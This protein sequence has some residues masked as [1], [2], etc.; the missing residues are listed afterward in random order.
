MNDGVR[1][2]DGDHEVTAVVRER[3]VELFVPTHRYVLAAHLPQKLAL[4]LAWWLIWHWIWATGCGLRTWL[5]SRA[6]R[7]KVLG[8]GEV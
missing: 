4:R 3:T 5:R 8:D 2:I 7:Q 1:L 6:M